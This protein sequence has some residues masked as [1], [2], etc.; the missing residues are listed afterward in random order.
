MAPRCSVLLLGLVL[1]TAACAPAPRAEPSPGEGASTRSA[2]PKR[3][4]I[5]IFGELTNVR[6]QV[7]TVTPGLTEIE[8]MINAGLAAIDDKGVMHPRLAEAVP[9]IENGLWKVFPD[10]RMETTWKIRPEARW[11]E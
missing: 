4:T 5:A 3:I 10:S 6:S 7:M 8:Q 1:V 2:A 11:H 9:S